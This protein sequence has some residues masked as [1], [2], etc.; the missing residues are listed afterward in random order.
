MIQATHIPLFIQL[1][2]LFSNLLLSTQ[3]PLFWALAGPL[4]S[5][6]CFPANPS[7]LAQR[8]ATQ[9]PVTLPQLYFNFPD[10][11]QLLQ[12][13]DVAMAVLWML[14]KCSKSNNGR[15]WDGAQVPGCSSSFQGL[16]SWEIFVQANLLKLQ[17]D[18]SFCKKT[19][20]LRSARP[21]ANQRSTAHSIFAATCTRPW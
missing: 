17:T 6:S 2:T 5:F 20:H 7:I 21:V 3:K 13:R 14:N 16:P 15:G 18:H 19:D 4:S 9:N 1:L 12:A 8:L 11:V 10:A